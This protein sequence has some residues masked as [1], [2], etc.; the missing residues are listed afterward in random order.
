[1]APSRGP[2]GGRLV[3]RTAEGVA[4][5][6]YP[7]VPGLTPVSLLRWGGGAQASAAVRTHGTHA[8]DFLILLYVEHGRGPIRVDGREWNLAAGDVFVIAPHAVVANPDPRIEP[9]TRAWMLYFPAEAVDPG[10]EAPL[11]AWRAPLL[12]PF[13]GARRGITQKL[14]VPHEQRAA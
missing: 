13:V 5:M 8:H 11:A 14:P 4:L 2:F 6:G 7:R 1:M 3:G 12:S 9:N 10:G